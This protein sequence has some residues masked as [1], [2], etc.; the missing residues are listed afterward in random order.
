M[1][2]HI[3]QNDSN[4]FNTYQT[5]LS[6]ASDSSPTRE[7]ISTDVGQ[8]R[9]KDGIIDEQSRSPTTYMLKWQ[10]LLHL[11]IGL[12]GDPARIIVQKICCVGV[13]YSGE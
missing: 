2:E 9:S 3:N 11:L 5:R 12:M 8:S 6:I 10:N 13:M 1:N 4:Q 7:P